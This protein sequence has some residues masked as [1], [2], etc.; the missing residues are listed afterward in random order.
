MFA[1]GLLYPIK[2]ALLFQKRHTCRLFQE[3]WLC[4]K[5][6][7]ERERGSKR[8]HKMDPYRNDS[9]F[10]PSQESLLLEPDF[11]QRSIEENATASY[12]FNHS[13][14]LR[15]KP[16]EKGVA[17]RNDEVSKPICSTSLFSLCCSF[18]TLS[19]YLFVHS[20]CLSVFTVEGTHLIYQHI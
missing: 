18:K 1:A 16:G 10:L 6:E 19:L 2:Q 4:F 5:S 11:L 20:L 9:Y 8:R 13:Q 15:E 3:L 17:R 7:R 12:F 14:L